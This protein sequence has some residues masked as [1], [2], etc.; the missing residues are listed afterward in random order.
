MFNRVALKEKAKNLLS[1]NYWKMVLVALILG[2][3]L[4][5]GP[6]LKF[7]ISGGRIQIYTEFEELKNDIRE[8]QAILEGRQFSPG[9]FLP[10]F[11]LFTVSGVFFLALVL[12]ILLEFVLFFP[13]QVS[14]KRF[15]IK[16]HETNGHAELSELGFVWRSGHMWNVGFGMFM[17]G[18]ITF[19]WTLLFIIPGI[20]KAYCYRM[21]PYL[22]AEDP[23]MN[24]SD[25]MQKSNDIMMGNKFETFV[26]DLSFIGWGILSG[27]TAGLLGI[28]F[29]TPYV[30]QTHAN[31]YCFLYSTT[32]QNEA[33][34]ET[35]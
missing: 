22:L 24:W 7:D 34:P 11:S 28:F 20:Y 18:L 10:S 35:F 16:N 13:L 32:P 2:L 33:I 19:L 17:S 14:C 4:S 25:A 27:L 12:G 26:L 15:F 31:L 23:T 8:M 6:D 29:V 3:V 5:N 9:Y 21:V 30:Y 1:F